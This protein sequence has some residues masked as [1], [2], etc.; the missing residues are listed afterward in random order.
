MKA[1]EYMEQAITTLKKHDSEAIALADWALGLGGELGEVAS[2]LL[3]MK[4]KSLDGIAP[5]ESDYM[6]LAKEAGDVLWYVFAVSKQLDLNIEEEE[7]I[8]AMQRIVPGDVYTQLATISAAVGQVQ[9]ACKHYIAHKEKF[10]AEAVRTSLEWIISTLNGTLHFFQMS[11]TDVAELNVAKLSHRY[12][13]GSFD[14]SASKNRHEKE[15]AFES[16][17]EYKT[18]KAKLLRLNQ[19]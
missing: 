6:E 1:K 15:R 12:N 17:E 11:L 13:K 5:E 9:E 14:N 3:R 4:E 7:G 10:D 2:A 16:T 19:F 8:L 18:I